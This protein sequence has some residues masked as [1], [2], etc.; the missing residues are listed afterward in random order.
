[1]CTKTICSDHLLLQRLVGLALQARLLPPPRVP[2]CRPARSPA[3]RARVC[4][5]RRGLHTAWLP[6]CGQLVLTFSRTVWRLYGGGKGLSVWYY[7]CSQLV[8]TF[9]R[10]VCNKKQVRNVYMRRNESVC[11]FIHGRIQN[12]YCSSLNIRRHTVTGSDTKVV[13]YSPRM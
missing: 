11:R 5:L 10:T 6:S 7:T 3:C 2:L 8:L 12:S 13:T 1:M 9:S 4:S